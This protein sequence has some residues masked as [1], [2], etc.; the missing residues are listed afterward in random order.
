MNALKQLTT[1]Q[2]F[3]SPTC[4]RTA[5]LLSRQLDEPLPKLTAFFMRTHL[6]LCRQCRA[7]SA[8]IAFIASACSDYSSKLG[9]V[10]AQTL[11]S[12]TRERLEA[13]IRE[14]MKED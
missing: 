8:N 10:S 7:Y 3:I 12:S 14:L 5:F 4:A 9:E 1:F 6:V 11:S 13:T 2:E